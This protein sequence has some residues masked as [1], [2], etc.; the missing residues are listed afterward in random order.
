[1]DIIKEAVLRLE[2]QHTPSLGE[3]R[4]A[5][6][7][8]IISTS[9][10]FAS[11][12]PRSAE[13]LAQLRI[14]HATMRDE[15]VHTAFTNLRTYIIQRMGKRS[16]SIVVTALVEG[17]GGSFVSMNLAA[18]F[19][20]DAS[21]AAILM[22]ANFGGA[23]F[24]Q[25]GDD[26]SRPGITDFIAGKVSTL[27]SLLTDPGVAG[28]RLLGGGT[29]RGVPREFFTHPRAPLLFEDIRRQYPDCAVVVDAP[30]ALLSANASVLAKYC[31]GVL[32]VVPYGRASEQDAR[33]AFRSMPG[34]KLLGSVFNDVP[35]W[36]VTG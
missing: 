23:R 7:R 14:Y 10:E 29:L 36:R 20:A 6:D 28:L 1:M 30:P 26:E 2:R 15:R 31:D 11:A 24:A 19:A 13:E 33:A 34:G 18:A 25:L 16:C 21:G 8:P 3:S 17:G 32:L 9:A 22:D 5:T 27:P 12:H 4:A 35:H